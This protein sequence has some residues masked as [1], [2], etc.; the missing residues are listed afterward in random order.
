M[1]LYTVS[2]G[3]LD[4]CVRF[5]IT[6]RAF[7]IVKVFTSK[8][9]RAPVHGFSWLVLKST[10]R[11]ELYCLENSFLRYIYRSINIWLQV[12]HHSFQPGVFNADL[13]LQVDQLFLTNRSKLEGD[14]NWWPISRSSSF[15][16]NIIER[17]KKNVKFPVVDQVTYKNDNESSRT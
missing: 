11:R 6:S 8:S 9:R 2:K 15:I 10:W 7:A 14:V 3:S 5:E 12:I 1:G 16:K 13:Q 17:F 4:D